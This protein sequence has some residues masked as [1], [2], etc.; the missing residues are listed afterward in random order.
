M[1]GIEDEYKLKDLYTAYEGIIKEHNKNN[2]YPNWIGFSEYYLS[3]PHISTDLLKSTIYP[4]EKFP[5]LL[6]LFGFIF[7][8]WERD[9]NTAQSMLDKAKND[10]TDT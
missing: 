10:I 2:S 7:D 8:Y 5:G 1:H 3:L 6:N 4:E 9:L